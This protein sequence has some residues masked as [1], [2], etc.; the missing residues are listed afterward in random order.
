[1]RLID[2]VVVVVVAVVV[3]GVVGVVGVL[4]VVDVVLGR[5]RRHEPA[6]RRRAASQPASERALQ[7]DAATQTDCMLAGQQSGAPSS[8]LQLARSKDAGRQLLE[9]DL[10]KGTSNSRDCNWA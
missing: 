7:L 4:V 8:R 5:A 6:S 3:V 10:R 1:M 9:A 2:Q